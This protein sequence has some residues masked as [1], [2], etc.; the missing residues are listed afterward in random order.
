MRFQPVKLRL[1]LFLLLIAPM[2]Y[3]LVI[4]LMVSTVPLF[5]TF[6]L[7]RLI[8]SCH[9]N[10]TML[11]FR[12][13]HQNYVVVAILRLFSTCT[14]LTFLANNL[15]I[16]NHQVYPD[17]RMHLCFAYFDVVRRNSLLQQTM[18]Q[19]PEPCMT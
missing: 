9:L 10:W 11:G 2:P 15:R 12:Y 14:H 1:N 8:T 3:T 19:L 5:N 6:S 4:I 18:R 13:L 17:V 7:H 16:P